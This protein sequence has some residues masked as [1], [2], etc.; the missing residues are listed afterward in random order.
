MKTGQRA[1]TL[2]KFEVDNNMAIHLNETQYPISCAVISSVLSNREISDLVLNTSIRKSKKINCSN[3]LISNK[4]KLSA[5]VFLASSARVEAKQQ[6]S[7]L[8]WA[9]TL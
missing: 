6:P 1:S 9:L 2:L 7:V 8:V 4:I 3:T 5:R